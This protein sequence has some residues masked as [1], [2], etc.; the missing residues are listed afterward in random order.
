MRSQ[1]RLLRALRADSEPRPGFYARVVDRIEKQGATSIWSILSE[2]PF[3]RRI[4][5]A[6]LALVVL[7]GIFLYTSDKSSE[8]TVQAPVVQLIA[9]DIAGDIPGDEQ[10]G[11]VLTQP[12]LP[13]RDAV[14]VNLVTYREQ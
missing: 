1:A 10:P 6:S 7:G 11:P 8:Q 9:G 2:S 13:D 5:T 12:G 3:G 14:L 4:A